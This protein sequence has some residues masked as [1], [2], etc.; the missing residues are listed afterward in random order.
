MSE[1]D[2]LPDWKAT[3]DL[4]SIAASLRQV[5]FT[6]QPQAAR[7]FGV[8]DS[9]ISRYE[10]YA[11]SGGGLKPRLGYLAA[12]MQE[13]EQR[14][15]DKRGAIT[16]YRQQ[17]V[18]K[19]EELRR[20][21]YA[22]DNQGSIRTWDDL[23]GCANRFR[24]GHKTKQVERDGGRL[25]LPQPQSESRQGPFLVPAPPVQG[26]FGRDE[27]LATIAELLS[28]DDPGAAGVEP[29][30][31]RGMGGIGKTTLAI[32]VGHR[33]DVA[34]QFP[35]GIL[36][37]AL[38]PN[39]VIRLQLNEWGQ[40]L[41]VDL[42]AERDEAAC[43]LRLR[44]VLYDRQALLII[45]D[46]WDIAHGRYFQVAGPRG[47]TLFTT[48]E[49]PVAHALATR[50][51]TLRVDVLKPAPALTFLLKLA[52]E[53]V[54]ADKRAAQTLC[55]K[56]EFLPLA[57]LLAGRLLAN[58]ADVPRRLRRLIDEL[59]E[60]GQAR[61]QLLQAEGRPGLAEDQPVSLQ[62]ILGMS[63][64]RLDQVDQARF[65]MLGTFGGEPLTWEI[66]A[67]AAVWECSLE[68]ADE[69]TARFIQRGLVEPRDGEY[70]THALMADYAEAMMKAMRL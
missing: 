68:E 66:E 41:G 11:P 54:A 42:K 10:N 21:F 62:A 61:L 19:L 43:Q 7:H 1:D 56:L 60:Q 17:A 4:W 37:T 57:L 13:I 8:A 47:R 6:T 14:V 52:P 39:P 27:D 23:C 64:N 5:V 24:A 12:L 31:L 22:G 35:D 55:E 3:D 70:W 36:W 16:T 26:V 67:A 32:A 49:S 15:A 2:L 34:Q 40:V 50:D 38:G 18:Q 51:R 58:E 63:V 65:A 25:S 29:L 44:D 46:V 69:T 28:L 59:T 30:A 45:D 33:K 48:R 53:A 20:R 9:T